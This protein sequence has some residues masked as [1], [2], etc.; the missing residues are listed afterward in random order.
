MKNATDAVEM[1]LKGD[2]DGAMNAYNRKSTASD[3]TDAD[4]IGKSE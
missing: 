4:S 3:H 1:I 2:I